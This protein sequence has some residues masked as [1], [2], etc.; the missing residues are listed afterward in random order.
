MTVLN[1]TLW[2]PSDLFLWSLTLRFWLQQAATKL[3]CLQPGQQRTVK[4][5]VEQ[6]V[7]H[8]TTAEPNMSLTSCRR[9]NIGQP[10]NV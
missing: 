10:N 6:L 4:G 3:P 1:L 9:S 8:L 5:Q 7:E 2:F